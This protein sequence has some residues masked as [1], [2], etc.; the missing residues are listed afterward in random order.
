MHESWWWSYSCLP[1][2]DL[3]PVTTW[4]W[5]IHRIYCFL[6]KYCTLLEDLICAVWVKLLI[7]KLKTIQP[8]KDYV[9]IVDSEVFCMF[10][11]KQNTKH[12]HKQ[13]KFCNNFIWG[14]Q[15]LKDKTVKN[16]CCKRMKHKKII[17]QVW[18][19]HS[20]KL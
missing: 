2:F 12:K 19:N 13:L 8:S 4:A 5:N 17:S 20:D 10:F 14:F 16:I 11:L 7:W 18:F 3:D 9:I 1:S 6:V 15:I